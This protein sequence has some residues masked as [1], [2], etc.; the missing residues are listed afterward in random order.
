VRERSLFDDDEGR[1]DSPEGVAR[2]RD[3]LVSARVAITSWKDGVASG[4]V[5][6]RTARGLAVDLVFQARLDDRRDVLRLAAAAAAAAKPAGHAEPA[7]DLPPPA[8]R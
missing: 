6:A 1:D 5:E 4:R 3:A 7:G 8:M 2:R